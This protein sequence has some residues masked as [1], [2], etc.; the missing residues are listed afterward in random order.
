[1][2][3]HFSPSHFR[4]DGESVRS[5]GLVEIPVI[6]KQRNSSG[7]FV[8][9]TKLLKLWGK[10]HRTVCSEVEDT[11]GILSLGWS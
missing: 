5:T 1:M 9:G 10:S 6:S 7:Y 4:I 3:S 8:L 2:L 11:A